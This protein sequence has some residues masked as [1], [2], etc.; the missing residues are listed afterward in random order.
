M[1]STPPEAATARSGAFR[2][3]LL[4]VFGMGAARIF[5]MVSS[6]LV[7]N[8]VGPAV[9][10]IW[11]TLRLIYVY[12][13]LNH[14]GVLEAYRKEFPRLRGAGEEESAAEVESVSLGMAHLASAVVL[15]GG[16]VLV[17]GIR[18]T[19]PDHPISIHAR[20]IF[21]MLVSVTGAT[22]TTFLFDRLA[23]RHLFE[24]A[25][26]I[27]GAR[28]VAYLAFL[29]FGAWWGG[30][31]GLCLGFALSEAAV[32]SVT[33]WL[34]R[35]KWSPIRPRLR[36]GRLVGMIG[37]GFPITLVWLTYLLGTTFD[38]VV[39]ISLLGAEATGYYFFGVTLASTLQ[40]LPEA[41][42]QVMNPRLNERMGESGDPRVIADQVW[43][44]GRML[45]WILPLCFGVL[46]IFVQPLY[47]TLF[48]KYVEGIT[49][50]R[51]L[52]M[53][54]SIV[55]FIPLGTSFLVAIHE[56]KKL[57]VV[58]PISLAFN[59][60]ANYTLVKAG[61][62]IGGVSVVTFAT[63]AMV[64]GYLWGRVGGMRTGS[65]ALES[66]AYLAWG[67]AA[68]NLLLWPGLR[69]LDF[70]TTWT[71]ACWGSVAFASAYVLV[72]A[73]VPF[74]RSWMRLDVR[75]IAEAVGRLR[76]Q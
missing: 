22:Y 27:R 26:L 25:S 50:G 43:G 68:A 20:A 28:G 2:H 18:F 59:L 53:A 76:K 6:F 74:S 54:A 24:E 4:M 1:N 56:Q 9:F 36:W 67:T 40:I 37:I 3:I 66:L 12:G 29:P 17:F 14:L 49:A 58:I 57:M 69:L 15:V 19:V 41:L 63:N 65:G 31:V 61:Y 60:A 73:A 39:T 21:W 71:S 75:R 32:A 72:L 70:G 7:A 35:G 55:A 47:E 48:P 51:I 10:G 33:M 46:A 30:L 42:S 52:V 5:G 8:L 34:G 16:A 45:S 44:I 38:R 23:T 64:A 13:G 62:G 11:G